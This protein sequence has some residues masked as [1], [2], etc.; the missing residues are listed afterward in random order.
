MSSQ[1]ELVVFAAAAVLILAGCLGV[2]VFYLLKWYGEAKHT[3]L[4]MLEPAPCSPSAQPPA[5]ARAPVSETTRVPR[6]PGGSAAPR[7]APDAD[8]T[9]AATAAERCPRGAVRLPEVDTQRLRD[10]PLSAEPSV[11]PPDDSYVAISRLGQR[12]GDGTPISAELHRQ[13]AARVGIFGSG[14]L[15]Q[16]PLAP[17]LPDAR[18]SAPASPGMSAGHYTRHSG[19]PGYLYLARNDLHRDGIYKLGYTVRTPSERVGRLNAETALMKGLGTFSLVEATPV[20]ASYDAEQLLFNA[21]SRRRVSSRREFFLGDRDLLRQ[22][23]REAAGLDPGD[24]RSISLLESHWGGD[25]V[26]RFVLPQDIQSVPPAPP[27]GGWVYLF[28]PH[29]YRQPLLYTCCSRMPARTVLA[30]LTRRSDVVGV[31]YLGRSH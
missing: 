21:L 13:E 5:A 23:L 17:P 9:G 18:Y 20:R 15:S 2:V 12:P 19:V 7:S 31:N 24:P 30:T 3:V 27:G 22:V 8:P 16:G 26:E 1:F 4:T 29:W 10:S 6:I 11:K 14:A 28:E 25:E